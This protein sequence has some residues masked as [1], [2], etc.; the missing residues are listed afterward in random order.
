LGSGVSSEELNQF[1]SIVIL[2][3]CAYGQLE[4]VA[5]WLRATRVP[6]FVIDHHQTRDNLA[7]HYLI[8][9]SAAANCLILHDLATACGWS[10]TL[11]AAE[12]LFVGIATDTGWFRHSNTD[13]R[14]FA[15]SA[16]LVHR[17]VVP[18]RIFDA[19]YQS[20]RQPRVRLLGK[21]I[22]SL[23]LL[24]HDRV[25]IMS[26]PSCAFSEVKAE[27]ADTEDIVNEPLRIDTVVVSLLLVE[28]EGIVRVN[29]RSRAPMEPGDADIDVSA[30]AAALGGGG[31]R[32]AAGVRVPGTLESARGKVLACLHSLLGK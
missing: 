28:Q 6:K 29:L 11:S 15:A 26:L 32:R 2:D 30:V 9:E 1:D 31:H 20:D 19:L 18:N 25:A 24:E 8:D 7:D 23:E 14:V 4:P 17:G 21:A 5:A 13:A 16:D 12:A 22:E 3:T 10:I 27:A